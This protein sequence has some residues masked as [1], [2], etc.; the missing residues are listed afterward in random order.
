MLIVKAKT[1]QLPETLSSTHYDNYALQL[2]RKGEQY[3]YYREISQYFHVDPGVYVVVPST[4]DSKAQ[5]DYLLRIYTD[6]GIDG[7]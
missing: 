3:Q 4:Y 5:A 1:D 6:S 7:R 2:A